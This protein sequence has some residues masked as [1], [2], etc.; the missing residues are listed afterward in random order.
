MSGVLEGPQFVLLHETLEFV[1]RLATATP[2]S[3]LDRSMIVASSEFIGRRGGESMPGFQPIGVNGG[4]VNDVFLWTNEIAQI[5]RLAASMRPV[6]SA[7]IQPPVVRIRVSG[8]T[9]P[10]PCSILL[11]LSIKNQLFVLCFCFSVQEGD[12]HPSKV[13]QSTCRFL[14]GEFE[15]FAATTTT[16][17]TATQAQLLNW[18]VK[19]PKSQLATDGQ[20]RSYTI[21][22]CQPR[23]VG[24]TRV[25]YKFPVTCICDFYK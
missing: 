1:L 12:A 14:V 8:Y 24:Y 19:I 10:A 21:R 18:R 11:F 25:S 5:P 13:T 20:S 15:N 9:F 22:G 2:P 3:P 6:L 23:G 7:S 4:G 16:T 17:T